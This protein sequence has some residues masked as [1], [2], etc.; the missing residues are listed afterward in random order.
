MTSLLIVGATGLVGHS[1]LELAKSDPR[2]RS[3]VAPTRRALP[4]HA[5]LQNP[6]VDFDKLPHDAPWWRVDA[7]IC[8]LGTTMRDAGSRDAFR[9]VD[10]NYPVA[11]ANH[12][13]RHGAT[14]FALNSAMGAN[15]ES[16]IFYNRV[17][18]EVEQALTALNFPSLT[19][20]RPGLIGGK[21]S[22][23]R[24]AELIGMKTL[25][26]IG[27]LLPRRYRVVPAE[28]IAKSLIDS[29]CKAIPGINII[30][31]ENI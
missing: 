24:P 21:R 26:A 3:I 8:T 30:E 2:V 23:V 1:V 20:V 22:T 25:L 29:A 17:K 11:V 28:R 7:A 12:V 19:I 13:R 4:R 16:R 31:S 27:L 15:A 5:K 14:A 10:F 9:K 6:V 18:G